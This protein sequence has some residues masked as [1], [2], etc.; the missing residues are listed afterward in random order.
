M[1][2]GNVLISG[3]IQ[4]HPAR[5]AAVVQRH[6]TP[7]N[8]LQRE[9][10]G[11]NRRIKPIGRAQ[12]SWSTAG[13]ALCRRRRTGPNPKPSGAR[14]RG[15]ATPC[16]PV[17]PR[18]TPCNPV[19]PRA[20]PCNPV[21]PRAPPCNTAPGGGRK[22]SNQTHWG[23]ARR[24]LVRPGPSRS[25]RGAERTRSNPSKP[26]ENHIAEPGMR[27]C[28]VG[29]RAPLRNEPTGCGGTSVAASSGC[30]T[31]STGRDAGV[32]VG[33]GTYDAPARRGQQAASPRRNVGERDG[34][35]KVS[36]CRYQ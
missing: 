1:S 30:R 27:S 26:M 18:A 35:A 15:R 5:A 6:A 14:R 13:I 17:Q 23:A 19:Q 24:A 11:A 28:S 32:A 7:C 8:A 10:Q 25:S 29:P 34:S 31:G 12:R 3:Q 9:A 33:T 4:S 20:T 36:A 22:S 2:G 21:Q 16:N